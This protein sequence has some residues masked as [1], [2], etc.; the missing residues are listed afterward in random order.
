MTKERSLTQAMFDPVEGPLLG[1]V[2][3]S[4]RDDAARRR[5]RDWLVAT[6]DPRGEALALLDA[7]SAP[8]PPPDAAARR[9]RLAALYEAIPDWWIELMRTEGAT[10][11]CGLARAEAPRVR[12]AFE[13]PRRWEMLTP[14]AD[15]KV[16]QCDGCG[17]PVVR[18]D[19]LDE[20]EGRAREGSCITVPA[21][22]VAAATER[23]TSMMTGRPHLP[24][25]W[26]RHLFDER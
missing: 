16:R 19:T 3:A 2:L 1:P 12:F 18:C 24:E 22:L 23:Y 11:H 5:Y 14:T 10:R 13:C 17:E 8:T 15:P 21:R 25:L 20:A 9:A 26:A 7:L 6:R 4:P